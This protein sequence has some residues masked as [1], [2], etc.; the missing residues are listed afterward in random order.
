M[1]IGNQ[2]DLNGGVWITYGPFAG[3][4][5]LNDTNAAWVIGDLLG[6]D[7]GSAVALGDVTGDGQADVVTTSD[8]L[9]SVSYGAVSPAM[10]FMITGRGM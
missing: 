5:E 6:E 4:R 8:G 7:A 2:R 10:L 1:V 9:A 3:S